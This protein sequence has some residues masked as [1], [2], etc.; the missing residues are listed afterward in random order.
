MN[1]GDYAG[2]R[3]I[4]GELD[5]LSMPLKALRETIGTSQ[6][7][8]AEWVEGMF[9]RKEAAG[10]N[11][12]EVEYKVGRRYDLGE[13]VHA[14]L[15]ALHGKGSEQR[16]A[17]ADVEN[18]CI[19]IMNVESGERVATVGSE[20]RGPGQ[21]E[22][23][24][25]VAFSATGELYVSD[26]DLHRISVLDHE[27][28]YVR[29]FG[30]V[31]RGEGQF[32]CPEGLC[33]T[34]D[35]NLVVADVWNHR[36]QI[37]REDGTF[38]R[39]FGSLGSEDGQFDCPFD[40]SVGPD[41]SIA[42]LDFSNRVQIFDGEGRFLRR[43]GSKGDGPG[44]V[45]NPVEVAHGAGGEII[46]ADMDRKDVQV[47]SGEG[48]LLQIIGADG[49]SKVAWHGRPWGVA[50]DAEGRIAVIGESDASTAPSVLLLSSS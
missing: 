34:A 25:G 6:N 9:D 20:G 35:G 43:I 14:T 48:E 44:H 3:E 12:Y 19:F 28:R 38:V 47:F 24:T 31:G 8:D 42:V 32:N 29:C 22:N 36:V 17:V 41:G 15:I 45:M 46:L 30:E 21:F 33:F 16:M 39:S 13:G 50:V 5:L 40:V 2:F 27:G 23:L 11:A 18:K 37:V 26:V 7:V 10:D 4:A 1:G 49:D